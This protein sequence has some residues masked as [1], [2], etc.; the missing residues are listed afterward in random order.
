MISGNHN[1]GISGILK[2]LKIYIVEEVLSKLYI[3]INFIFYF[4]NG[5]LF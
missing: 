4:C 2:V 5:K 1:S 3:L